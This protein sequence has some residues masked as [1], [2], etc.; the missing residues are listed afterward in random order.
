MLSLFS[1]SYTAAPGI[2][3]DMT[4]AADADIAAAAA[5]AGGQCTRAQRDRNRTHIHT[6]YLLFCSDFS[7]S[8]SLD[9][10][11]F[12]F[13]QF[14]RCLASFFSLTLYNAA[15]NCS[16]EAA[17]HC[18]RQTHLRGLGICG[19]TYTYIR[20]MVRVGKMRKREIERER[21][22]RIAARDFPR[23]V[24]PCQKE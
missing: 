23:C 8:L 16:S 1:F 24:A 5:S 21:K 4:V 6:T 18:K 22:V 3:A 17:N 2:S 15:S 9:F 19:V 10:F 20:I 12:F 7:L 13:V 11:N 14:S